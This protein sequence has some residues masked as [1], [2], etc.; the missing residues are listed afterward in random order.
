MLIGSLIR[1]I[2][3]LLSIKDKKESDL[4][5]SA[6]ELTLKNQTYSST[7]SGISGLSH[8]SNSDD[9][10]DLFM[11]DTLDEEMHRHHDPYLNPGQDI[12][13]DE[14]YHGIDHSHHDDY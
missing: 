8:S 2:T 13:V 3:S 7:F 11:H 4:M 1:K 9:D 10:F 5:T 14:V 12:V 6:L